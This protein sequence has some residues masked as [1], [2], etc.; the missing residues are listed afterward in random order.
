MIKLELSISLLQAT[1]QRFCSSQNNERNE[2]SNIFWSGL[3]IVEFD[4]LYLNRKLNSIIRV[5]LINCSNRWPFV[6]FCKSF[7][8]ASIVKC[9][10]WSNLNKHRSSKSKVSKW[11]KIRDRKSS[12]WRIDF[13]YCLLLSTK[14]SVKCVREQD[15]AFKL[16]TIISPIW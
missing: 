16:G 2:L 15:S 13:V 10:K 12:L 3:G 14:M 5:W 6:R 8:L 9:I 7:I 11:P 4:K 1:N